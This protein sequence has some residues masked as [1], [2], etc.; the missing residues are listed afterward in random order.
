VADHTWAAMKG[1]EALRVEWDLGPNQSFDSDH[2]LQQ[3]I[4]AARSRDGYYVRYDGDAT[5]ALSTAAETMNA[6][7]VSPFQAHAPVET[8]NCVADVRRNS[9]E[10]W[11]P[12]QC[13]EE[14]RTEA[15][16]MLG[17]PPESVTLHVT[18]IG[19]GL[20]LSPQWS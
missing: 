10:I 6:V 16:K 20:V 5:K 17:L 14:A 3:E 13:P 4:E 19:G 11:A 1:R 8:M 9:C 2:F 15:A 12:T 18:L 7:Y